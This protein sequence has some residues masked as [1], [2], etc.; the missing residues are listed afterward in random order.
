MSSDEAIE[1]YSVDKPLA[2]KKKSKPIPEVSGDP[3][4]SMIN[5]LVHIK[6]KGV[7]YASVTTNQP[8]ITSYIIIT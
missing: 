1:I 2:K 5:E 6:T 7:F 8:K 3:K 4:K